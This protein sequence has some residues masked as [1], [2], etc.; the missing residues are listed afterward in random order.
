MIVQWLISLHTFVFILHQKTWNKKKPEKKSIICS[1][2]VIIEKIFFVNE[3]KYRKKWIRKAKKNMYHD[4]VCE[5]VIDGTYMIVMLILC[6]CCIDSLKKLEV[7]FCCFE[8]II[9]KKRLI[10][11]K[12]WFQN[13]DKAKTTSTKSKTKK[14]SQNKILQNIYIEKAR[15]FL[16][17]I[18]LLISLDSAEFWDDDC[19]RI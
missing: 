1:L 14:N 17:I 3:Y 15:A 11:K 10:L 7:F 9:E 16:D 19:L 12:N 8:I 4:K 2:L 6:W 5:M 13:L 18:C